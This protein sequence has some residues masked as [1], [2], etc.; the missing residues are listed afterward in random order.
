MDHK[1]W[2]KKKKKNRYQVINRST[3]KMILHKLLTSFKYA[4]NAL[5][6][7]ACSRLAK[8]GL[9][10][11]ITD[12]IFPN[13][14]FNCISEYLNGLPEKDPG[15]D[16]VGQNTKHQDKRAKLNFHMNVYECN[17]TN[18]FMRWKMK[19]SVRWGE[20]ELNGTFHLSPNENICSIVQLLKLITFHQI[21][22][23]LVWWE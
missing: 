23:L 15:S 3:H 6:E 9:K 5:Q 7:T 8:I 22:S 20:A 13:L 1:F 12:N 16:K 18:I 14:N 19:Y 21:L 17:G 4:T 11:M 10:T 2:K